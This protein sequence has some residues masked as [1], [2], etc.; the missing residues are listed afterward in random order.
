MSNVGG[1]ASVSP[2]VQPMPFRLRDLRLSIATWMVVVMLLAWLPLLGFAGAATWRLIEWR[3]GD[4][5]SALERRASVTASAVARELASIRSAA[6]AV[7]L[8]QAALSG[9]LERLH[10]HCARLVEQDTRLLSISVHNLAGE[11]LLNTRAAFGTPAADVAEVKTLHAS[12][13]GSVDGASALTIEPGSGRLALVLEVPF[14]TSNGQPLF[15]HVVVTPQLLNT[16]L[17]EQRWPASWLGSVVDQRGTIIARSRDAE[18]YV[19]QMASA[20]LRERLRGQPTGVYESVTNDQIPV[21]TASHEVPGTR[22]WVNVGQPIGTLKSEAR[23]ALVGLAVVGALCLGGGLIGALWLARAVAEASRRG[24]PSRNVVREI[25]HL[26]AQ[27]HGAQLDPLT[28][29]AGRRAF[30]EMGH[31]LLTAAAHAPGRGL[32]LLFLDLDGFKGLNDRL[33]HAAG[34]RALQ[35]VAK[36]LREHARSDDLTARLGGDEFVLALQAPRDTL[37]KVSHEVGT[38]LIQAVSELPH[39]LGCS[40]GLAIARDGEALDA[41]LE[42]AD[43]AMYEAKRAGRGRVITAT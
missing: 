5:F 11:Q 34:D 6:K 33:G 17:A 29:L 16:V 25:G 32:A 18:R 31:Q 19:G 8:S 13:D 9:D 23:D 22:W 28:G 39:E 37:D 1:P 20:T 43:R 30:L 36:V 24:D 21:Y 14:S 10:A 7:V 15:L 42:R 2:P 27:L 12:L 41:L 40:I 4:A 26:Q 38:R 35:D 3:E